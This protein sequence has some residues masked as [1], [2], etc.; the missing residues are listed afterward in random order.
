MCQDFRVTG[1]PPVKQWSNGV[2]RSST[3]SKTKAVLGFPREEWLVFN[4]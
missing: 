4:L 1:C 2:N 3:K